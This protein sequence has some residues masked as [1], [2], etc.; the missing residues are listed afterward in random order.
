ME[1]T[2]LLY[3]ATGDPYYLRVGKEA[4]RA[5]QLHAWVPCGYAAV[6]DV[7]T[8]GHEDR[9]DSFVLSETFKYLYLLFSK[10]EELPINL[11][12]FVFTTEAHLLPL[13]LAKT[14]NLSADALLLNAQQS[15]D[16]DVEFYSSCPNAHSLFPGK[17]QFAENIRKPLKNF[18]DSVCPSRSRSPL[19]RKLKASDFLP[20]SDA[21]VSLLKDMGITILGLP[22]GRVQL[23][24]TSSTVSHRDHQFG[25]PDGW[26]QLLHT[27]STVS[28]GNRQLGLP[29]GRVQ[30][31]H[32]SSSVSH[33]NRQ[34]GLPD[35][36]IQ[37]L[38]TSST[39]SRGSSSNGYEGFHFLLYSLSFDLFCL[40]LK[41][42]VLSI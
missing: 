33:G 40:K 39:K 22:D 28:H 17:Q 8:G 3:E 31:L 19:T 41:S 16:T 42:L 5:L 2:Y 7:R 21:H 14:T 11:D 1:S 20:G 24:H 25:L 29:D 34:L 15:S 6:K 13:S 9:M 12:D 26:V 23:L 4:L 32:T 37:L 30:L 38:H 36:M 35:G 27:S 18:V 10:P